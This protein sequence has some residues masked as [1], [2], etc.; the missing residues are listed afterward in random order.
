MLVGGAV[1]RVVLGA[2]DELVDV[3]VALVIAGIDREGVVR[4]DDAFGV[5]V[6]HATECGALD[7]LALRIEGVDLDHPAEAVRLIAVLIQVETRIGMVPAIAEAILVDAVTV[8]ERGRHEGRVID[9]QAGAVG[10]TGRGTVI[11]VPVLFAGQ[12]GVPGGVAG[13][14]V[15]VGAQNLCAGA[16]GGGLHQIV[17]GGRAA[18]FHRRIR[19]DATAI[20]RGA[21]DAPAVAGLAHFDDRDAHCCLRGANL[22]RGDV[23][24]GQRGVVMQDA[25]VGVLIVDTQH[26]AIIRQPA[27]GCERE[28][29]HAINVHAVLLN[30]LGFGLGA[31]RVKLG[32]IRDRVAPGDQHADRIAGGN[33]DLVV[34]CTGCEQVGSDRAEAE[35]H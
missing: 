21:H 16:V 31:G 23:F 24:R 3:F 30:L 10:R 4:T 22:C 33:G 28:E 1:G 9:D 7:R 20:D 27:A 29:V 12:E 34:G 2:R 18:D 35:A 8:L 14:A 25:F 6:L 13:G 32:A 26:A 17:T 19:G 11:A 5:F 15:V